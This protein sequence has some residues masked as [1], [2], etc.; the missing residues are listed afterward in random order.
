MYFPKTLTFSFCFPAFAVDREEGIAGYRPTRRLGALL[1]ISR[2][3]L[4]S[5]CEK[6]RTTKEFDHFN[7][8]F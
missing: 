7:R 1:H 3:A 4:G 8:I 2:L 6:T 5:N